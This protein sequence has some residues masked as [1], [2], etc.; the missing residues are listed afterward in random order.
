MSEHWP[1]MRSPSICLVESGL[2]NGR[3]SIEPESRCV[4]TILTVTKRTKGDRGRDV[5]SQCGWRTYQLSSCKRPGP[6]CGSDGSGPQV[7][8]LFQGSMCSP[9]VRWSRHNVPV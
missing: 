9:S 4:K 5:R 3:T 6:G 8:N 1:P 7:R 2:S